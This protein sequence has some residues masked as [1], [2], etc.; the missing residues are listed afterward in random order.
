[1]GADIEVQRGTPVALV[2]A[3]GDIDLSSASAL[4]AAC[5]EALADQPAV[6]IIDLSGVPF[7]DS[8]GLGAL[9]AAARK[10]DVHGGEVRIAGAVGMVT[11]LLQLAGV[12]RV[13]PLYPTREAASETAPRG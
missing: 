11:R 7:I 1:V 8:T 5:D 3:T 6:L 13:L 12:E 2:V 10:A 4:R 9:I